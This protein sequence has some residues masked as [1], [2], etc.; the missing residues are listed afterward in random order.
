MSLLEVS[1][2]HAGYGQV[3]VLKD[4]SLRVEEG[5]L[6]LLLG[7]N[8]AGKTTLLRALSGMCDL[9][10][11]TIGLGDRS[12]V[13]RKAHEMVSLGVAHIPEGRQLFKD[14]TVFENLDLGAQY[15]VA[16][17]R[18]HETIHFVFSL[19]PVLK[20]R[21]AQRAGTL[22]GGEQQMLAIGRGLMARHR[23]L[24][25]DEP[26]TGLSP[27]VMGVVMEALGKIAATGTG[28]ILVEQILPT[29]LP[30]AGN[31][32]VLRDGVVVRSAPSHEVIAEK[33]LAATYL[34]GVNE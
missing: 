24:L 2:L 15:P 9:T 6:A 26:S 27:L 19:F 12:L 17:A 21:A 28:L 32:H 11:G 5:E 16:R 8:G 31:A 23:L 4:V 18:R 7:P 14:M 20:S 1:G 33:S 3:R 34:G 10:A 13:G 25:L 30:A 22:S 29:S